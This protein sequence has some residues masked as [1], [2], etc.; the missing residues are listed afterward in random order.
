MADS[1]INDY[2]VNLL[3]NVYNDDLERLKA[4]YYGLDYILNSIQNNIETDTDAKNYNTLTTCFLSIGDII[5]QETEKE[6]V[7]LF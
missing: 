6:T 7:P 1:Y 2:I 5:K 4:L 3:D